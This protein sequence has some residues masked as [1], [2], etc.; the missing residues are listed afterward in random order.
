MEE[1]LKLISP[2]M[3]FQVPQD[4]TLDETIVY[5]ATRLLANTDKRAQLLL[6]G[7]DLP[8]MS[9]QRKALLD[10]PPT[11]LVGTGKHLNM[12][13]SGPKAAR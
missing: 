10:Q 9:A 4:L 5:R 2:S 7:P 12:L 6:V 13:F 1:L 11:I 8:S 3:N